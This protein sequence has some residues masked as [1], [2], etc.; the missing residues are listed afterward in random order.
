MERS[1]SRPSLPSHFVAFARRLPPRAPV[2]VA[3][4]KPDAGLGPRVFGSGHPQSLS[5]SRRRRSGVPSSWGTPISVCPVQPTPAGLLAPDRYSAA[6]W[7]LVCE[8]Q[9]LPRK[10]FRRSIAGLSDSLST[11]RRAGYP[12]PTQDSLPAVGQTLLNG[13]PPAGLRR[14]VSECF[15]TSPPP[16]PSLLGAI[17]S[18]ERSACTSSAAMH[19]NGLASP[20]IGSVDLCPCVASV[21]GNA[22]QATGGLPYPPAGWPHPPRPE[23]QVLHQHAF[24]CG[25]PVW[26]RG[27]RLGH[28]GQVGAVLRGSKQGARLGRCLRR[29]VSGQSQVRG[30]P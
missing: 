21:R 5:L 22:G 28:T 19:A 3:P 6:A 20:A 9:R 14:K 30:T 4:H 24:S 25:K 2:F 18:T 15:V 10:V 17:T 27:S 26:P 12:D 23:A 11:L 16:F 13:L 1:D 8:K 29:T 7:P